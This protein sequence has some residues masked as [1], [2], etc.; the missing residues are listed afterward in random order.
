MLVIQLVKKMM[1]ATT[2]INISTAMMKSLSELF[3]VKEK[4]L[5]LAALLLLSSI[6]GAAFLPVT[7]VFFL[8]SFL[9]FSD[10][11]CGAMFCC[12]YSWYF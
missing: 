9:M 11:V 4:L 12:S 7:T 2:S 8:G 10:Y 1:R 6:M 3:M 5:R